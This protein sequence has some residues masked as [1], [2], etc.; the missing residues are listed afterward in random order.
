MKDAGA[1]V[2]DR[3]IT[4]HK[5]DVFRLL[6]LLNADDRV[7]VAGSV[8]L[9]VEGFLDAIVNEVVDDNLLMGRTKDE[10]ISILRQIYL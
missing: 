8:R 6:P 3:D 7:I 4:K 2:N 9:A 10:A 1:S 5:N